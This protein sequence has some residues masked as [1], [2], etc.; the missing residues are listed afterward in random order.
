VVGKCSTLQTSYIKLIAI[1]STMQ[2]TL[3]RLVHIK[4]DVLTSKSMGWLSYSVSSAFC[5]VFP[6]VSAMPAQCPLVEFQSGTV[7]VSINSLA[8]ISIYRS[9]GCGRG[10]TNSLLLLIKRINRRYN[11]K[12]GRK[13][14]RKLDHALF[15]IT[16]LQVKHIAQA[17]SRTVSIAEPIT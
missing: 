10:C 2:C 15:I 11:L 12:N 5:G 9:L 1:V 7:L 17:S 8:Q 16:S 14:T 13:I 6:I 4:C 3:I